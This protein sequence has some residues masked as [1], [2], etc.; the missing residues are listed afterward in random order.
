MECEYNFSYYSVYIISVGTGVMVK[1]LF[2]VAQFAIYGPSTG[3]CNML[4]MSFLFSLCNDL[5]LY[6]NIF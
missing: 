4:I 2:V 1:E 6:R 3:F 5:I